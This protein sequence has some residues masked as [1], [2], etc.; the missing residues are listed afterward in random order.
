MLTIP[1]ALIAAYQESEESDRIWIAD[2]PR[3]A[4]EMLDRWGLRVDGEPACGMCALVVP[5]RDADGA[6]AVLKL[7]PIGDETVGEP[8]ALGAWAGRGAVRLLRHD[9]GNGSML[10]ERLDATRTLDGVADDVAALRTLSANLAVLTAV[11]APPGIR[12]L[13]DVAADLLERAPAAATR[14]PH[15]ALLR[16][17]AHATAEVLPESGDRLLHW[18]LH[19]ANVLAGVER[20][21]WLAIDPKPLAGDP[22]FDLLPALHN[23]W[24]DVV[25]TGDVARAV[26]RRFDLMVE[27]VGLDRQ[28]AVRWTLA[29]V[30]QQLIWNA[31]TGGASWCAD[32]E[33]DRAI[34]EAL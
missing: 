2:L 33:P 1:D 8:V 28:R 16:R 29:R 26:R 25:A 12:R 13:A 15:P 14:S 19:Y 3:L 9:P 23:R 32:V 4:G 34:A 22:A 30:L 24:D 11:A 7:Q 21:E 18:D 27:V 5:V 17:C 6:G 10:L 31:E 20:A